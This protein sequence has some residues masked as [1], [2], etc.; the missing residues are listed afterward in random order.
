M[1]Q[2]STISQPMAV[3]IREEKKGFRLYLG[4]IEPTTDKGRW[5]GQNFAAWDYFLFLNYLRKTLPINWT[6]LEISHE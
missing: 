6:S 4:Q 3:I 1:M 2:K 5:S